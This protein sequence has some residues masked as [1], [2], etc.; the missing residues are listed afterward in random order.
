MQHV[1]RTFWKKFH[2]HL[3]SQI[4]VYK[5]F[6]KKSDKIVWEKTRRIG[7]SHEV[8]NDYF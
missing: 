8:R 1:K 5:N 6:S 3:F 4:T 7:G 2:Y